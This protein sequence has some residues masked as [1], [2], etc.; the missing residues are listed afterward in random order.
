VNN[1]NPE[2]KTGFVLF[3]FVFGSEPSSH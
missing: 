3:F 2:S 1:T